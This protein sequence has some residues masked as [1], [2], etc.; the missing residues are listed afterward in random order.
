[1]L[2]WQKDAAYVAINPHILKAEG[3][4]A[5]LANDP[6]G[7]TMYGIA[8]NYNSGTL[9]KLGITRQTMRSLTKQQALQIYYDK[10]WLASGCNKIQDKRLALIHFD[11]AV[12]QGVGLAGKLLKGLSKNPMNYEGNGKNQPLFYGLACEY[13]AARLRTYVSFRKQANFLPGWVN[14]MAHMLEVMPALEP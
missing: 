14:R 1:M 11:C 8:W 3:G 7:P 13:V 12:N 2:A 6:G 9:S 4:Y 10:Y 5:D